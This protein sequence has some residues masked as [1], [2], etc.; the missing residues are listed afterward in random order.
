M[1]IP[2]SSSAHN[3]RTCSLHETLRVGI[4]DSSLVI[5]PNAYHAFM[6]EKAALTA[7]LLARF[8]E[9]VLIRRRA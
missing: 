7:D 1:P 5:I 9:D 3:F 4:P 8:A 6:L 2:S